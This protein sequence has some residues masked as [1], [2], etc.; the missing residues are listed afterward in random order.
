MRAWYL[1]PAVLFLIAVSGPGQFAAAVSIDPRDFRTIELVAFD[2]SSAVVL[3]ETQ[4][5]AR[6]AL[7][8]VWGRTR[9]TR[10]VHG[11]VPALRAVT[12]ADNFIAVTYRKGRQLRIVAFDATG[13]KL[14]STLAFETQASNY[15]PHL[16]A[17][18]V[19]ST[20]IAWLEFGRS[21]VG[22]DM[23][24]GKKVWRLDG[25]GGLMNRVSKTASALIVDNISDGYSIDA[26]TGVVQSSKHAGLGCVV[27]ND[28]VTI[29]GHTLT[30][31]EGG[32]LSK[33][34]VRHIRG[35]WG[36][37]GSGRLRACGRYENNLVVLLAV[38]DGDSFI[39]RDEIA[40]LD[41]DDVVRSVQLPSYSIL[42]DTTKLSG[43]LP[44]FIPFLTRSDDKDQWLLIDLQTA[45]V[46]WRGP[47]RD[48]VL[49]QAIRNG[50]R[51]YVASSYP[52][53]AV[54]VI[55]GDT[56]TAYASV[57]IRGFTFDHV[58]PSHIGLTKLWLASHD[59]AVSVLDRFT[60]A[61]IH[62][63]KLTIER[64]PTEPWY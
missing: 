33:A 30:R 4:D 39:E 47:I 3:S 61:A 24:T 41:G 7:V 45:R 8:D 19:G 14:W 59:G 60:L 50:H 51:W 29:R 13:R 12:T 44:R 5:D 63:D 64:V 56:G 34:R 36:A 32:D 38:S 26:R 55:D 16:D 52:V 11:D 10:F 18:V 42:D 21:M 49:A 20:L 9:W 6:V 22:L 62:V 57:K 23:A 15:R 31:F 53:D 17:V 43:E 54:T 46:S 2:A 25:P 1:V 48:A 40:I 27:D 28:Y 58:A 35:D 37:Q